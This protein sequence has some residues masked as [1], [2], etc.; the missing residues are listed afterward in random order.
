MRKKNPAATIDAPAIRHDILSASKNNELFSETAACSI[1]HDYLPRVSASD[2]EH[3]DIE[4][5]E[6]KASSHG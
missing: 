2:T 3:E 1:K 6:K 5:C 4:S